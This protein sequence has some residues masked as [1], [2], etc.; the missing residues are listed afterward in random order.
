MKILSV[1]DSRTI[2]GTIRGMVE[3]I[4]AEFLEAEDGQKGI[5]LLEAEQGNIDLIILD[6]EMPVMNGFEFLAK[7]KGD[8][9]FKGI[10]VIMLTTVNMKDR[11]IEAIR[12]GAKQYMTKPFTSEE[13][14][15]K[16]INAVGPEN[17]D[18]L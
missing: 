14:L 17:L 16:I 5:D 11:M 9:R 12:M 8:E 1:D 18:F 15:T 2:R 3:V 4:G 10:P 13:L 7:V 6:I